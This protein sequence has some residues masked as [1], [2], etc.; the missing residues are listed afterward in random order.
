MQRIYTKQTGCGL[1]NGGFKASRKRMRKLKLEGPYGVCDW[2]KGGKSD[3]I[4]KAV[5]VVF[6]VVIGITEQISSDRLRRCCV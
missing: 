2:I 3:H 6:S 5:S 1:K 4:S